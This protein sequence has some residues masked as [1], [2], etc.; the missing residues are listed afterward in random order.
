MNKEAKIK[1]LPL[2]SFVL[3]R[4]LNSLC[5][6][7]INL[8]QNILI[9]EGMSQYMGGTS[10]NPMKTLIQLRDSPILVVGSNVENKLAITFKLLIF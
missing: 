9:R 5:K 1:V 6:V 7:I 10:N 3:I 2:E 4:V 8:I